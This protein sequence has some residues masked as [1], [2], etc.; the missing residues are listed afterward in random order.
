MMTIDELVTRARLDG[1]SDV[2]LICGLPP[3]Y[4]KDGQVQDMGE[5]RLTADDC[6][7]I[8]KF[9]DYLETL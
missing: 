6:V 8:A 2:H 5:E 1:A 4:R 3:K 9:L 7:A